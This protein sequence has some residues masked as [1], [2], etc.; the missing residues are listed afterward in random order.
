ML[1]AHPPHLTLPFLAT[2]DHLLPGRDWQLSGH[3][4][5]FTETIRAATRAEGMWLVM[6]DSHGDI[7]NQP[8]DRV[9]HAVIRQVD[10]L[11]GPQIQVELRLAQWGVICPNSQHAGAP[12][13]SAALRP[14]WREDSPVP[15]T[16]LL[17][18]KYVQWQQEYGSPHA[19]I[20]PTPRDANASWLCWRWLELLPLPVA[21][22]QRLLRH[23]SPTTCLRYL[24]KIVQHGDLCSNLLR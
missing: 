1:P 10:W 12:T 18:Q 2:T 23:P 19:D 6:Q 24:E 15:A 9:T 7:A 3:G 5:V 11:S 16:H 22:K 14:L 17:L 4:I 13:L 8:G 20:P 21:T